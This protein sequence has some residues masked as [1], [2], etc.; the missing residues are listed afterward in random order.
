[1]A[2][3]HERT[4]ARRCAAQVLYSTAIRNMSAR[5][6]LDSNLMDCLEAPL[7][8]YAL[9]LI[10]GVEDNASEIDDIISGA[11]KNWTLE[12]MPV[13]DVAIT[14]IALFEMLHVDDVPVSVSINEAVELAKRFGGE[15]DSPKFVNGMLG[16]VARQMEHGGHGG[17]AKA[18]LGAKEEA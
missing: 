9:K 17:A 2:R 14:R 12:R 15:D 10:Y 13:M 5:D 16:S 8:D 1:M 4:T 7:S 6:L 18:A 11:A 3:K